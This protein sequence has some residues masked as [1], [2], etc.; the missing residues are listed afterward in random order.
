MTGAIRDINFVHL[1]DIPCPAHGIQLRS[2]K[3]LFL[4]KHPGFLALEQQQCCLVAQEA[5]CFWHSYV[6]GHAKHQ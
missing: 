5:P 6:F 1:L 2:E 4:C 3:N